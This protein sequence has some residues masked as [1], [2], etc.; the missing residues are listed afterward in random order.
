MQI[1]STLLYITQKV[2][3]QDVF[4]LQWIRAF[5][6]L[7]YRVILLCLDGSGVPSDIESY[8]MGKEKGY[9]RVHQIFLF[10]KYLVQLRYDRV[11]IHLNPVW[12]LLGSGYWILRRISVYLWYTHYV[13]SASVRVTEWYAQRI[14]CATEQSVPWRTGVAVRSSTDPLPSADR[15]KIVVGHGVDTT[16]WSGRS[17]QCSDPHA[18]LVVHR[19]SRSKRLE[20]TLRALTHLPSVYRLTVYG[21]AAEPDYAEEMERL[22][23]DLGLSSRVTFIGTV[24]KDQLPSIYAAHRLILN[25]ASETIDK[26]MLEAMTCGC[27]P[28]TTRRNAE[29]IGLPVVSP[30]YAPAGER[31]EDIAAFIQSFHL[32][33]TDALFRLVDQRHNLQRLI[34]LLDRFI[35]IGM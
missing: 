21:I 26:T 15:K 7:G 32:V 30:T 33:D 35:R 23:V 14:F 4:I 9:S 19:L 25:M 10:F 18:L 22:S 2:H 28:V 34:T 24:A 11:F 13:R 31:P 6:R 17:N 12:G 29:A 3:T 20:I 16:F 8:S 1:H 27:Y 5:Q